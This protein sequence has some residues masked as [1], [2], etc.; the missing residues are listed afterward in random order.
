MLAVFWADPVISISLGI[1]RNTTLHMRFV[2]FILSPIYGYSGLGTVRS[3]CWSDLLGCTWLGIE[4]DEMLRGVV[5]VWGAA[6]CVH[7]DTSADGLGISYCRLLLWR[8]TTVSV[9]ALPIRYAQTNETVIDQTLLQFR[10]AVP[11]N[12]VISGIDWPTSVLA[13]I[14][15]GAGLVKVSYSTVLGVLGV[16]ACDGQRE[17]CHPYHGLSVSHGFD[18]DSSH[19]GCLPFA[20][21]VRSRITRRQAFTSCN[22]S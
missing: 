6:I 15:L 13:G 5:L 8:A 19:V 4:A 1:V 18:L 16:C 2:A 20:D 11:V 3:L 22:K 7:D 9:A 10:P 17:R 14:Q 21:L 12:Q